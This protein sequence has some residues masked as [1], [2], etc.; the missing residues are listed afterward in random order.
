MAERS[1]YKTKQ[2]ELLISYLKEMQGEHITAYDACEYLKSQGEKIGQSTVYRQ[3]ER[4]VDEGIVSKYVVDG[5][6]SACF[7]YT[8]E[9][10]HVSAGVCFHCKCEVCGKLIHMHCGELEEI[11]THLYADH[12]FRLNPMRTVFYGVCDACM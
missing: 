10:S 9:E 4:L 7:E 5:S 12:R 6:T 11:G 3:L 1:M 2:R 8:G